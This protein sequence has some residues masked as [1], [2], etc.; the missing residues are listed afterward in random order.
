M[1]SNDPNLGITVG[2]DDPATITIG[3]AA[4]AG[5]TTLS[6]LVVL[7]N[8][9]NHVQ[10]RVS[11]DGH[12][13]MTYSFAVTYIPPAEDTRLSV[14]TTSS[15]VLTPTFSQKKF[16][17][18]NTI[19]PDTV[20]LVVDTVQ[21]GATVSIDGAPVT[22]GTPHAVSGLMPGDNLVQVMVVS[23][24]ASKT[25]ITQVNVHRMEVVTIAAVRAAGVHTPPMP[26]YFYGIAIRSRRGAGSKNAYIQTVGV[27][28]G[29]VL[30]GDAAFNFRTGDYL[31]VKYYK[32]DLYSD[33]LQAYVPED[34][35]TI[36]ESNRQDD[37]VFD[38]VAATPLLTDEGKYVRVTSFTFGSSFSD[39][40][41]W[42]API[43]FRNESGAAVAAGTY[44]LYGHVGRYGTQSQVMLY[45]QSIQVFME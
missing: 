15:G 29:I 42:T 33:L 22:K 21:S 7:S 36:L 26:R 5:V 19:E 3:G 24:D 12:Q 1:F 14:L 34:G 2:V 10:V 23:P 25:N 41:N 37:L 8:G 32:T 30:R 13:A 38:T 39:G 11:R 4:Q 44:T 43:Y 17:Y 6:N 31:R 20:S 28:S 27:N 16:F 40:A 35:I 9:L 18:T 45:D